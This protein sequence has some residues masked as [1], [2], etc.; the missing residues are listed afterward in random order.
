MLLFDGLVADPPFVLPSPKTLLSI[1]LFSL[2]AD[3]RKDLGN[4]S[5][6]E[7]VHFE[8]ASRTGAILAMVGRGTGDVS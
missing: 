3:C 1:Q 2:F 6:V 7:D 8:A 5:K 4:Y